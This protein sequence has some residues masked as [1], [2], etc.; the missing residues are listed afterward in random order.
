MTSLEFTGERY[1]PGQGGSE[2]AYEHWHR[3]LY[4]LRW[5]CGRD[6]LDLGS[7]TGYGAELLAGF[8]RRVWAVD[9]DTETVGH[10]RARYSSSNL[11]YLCADAAR[12]PMP[13]CS[14]DL[15]AAFEILEHLTDPAQLVSEAARVIRPQGVVLISTPN[16]ATYSDAR[17][18]ANPFHTQEY[19]RDELRALLHSCFGRVAIL[20]QRMRAG[21][22]I[23]A[24]D[25]GCNAFHEIHTSPLPGCNAEALEGMYFIAICSHEAVLDDRPSSSAYLDLTDM[26]FR[27]SDVRLNESA[28]GFSRLRR[29]ANALATE[30]GALEKRIDELNAEVRSREEEI[31]RLRNEFDAG[32]L[33]P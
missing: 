22:L 30:K 32:R 8:A 13:S 23:S 31:L 1:V 26:F 17:N 12:L 4:S 18:Y 28:A 25:S 7:G 29:K 5:A 20:D 16:K 6:V 9:L 15:V 10:A 33:E 27:E 24:G 11:C 19:Y 3:Y 14:V 2:I 21:S